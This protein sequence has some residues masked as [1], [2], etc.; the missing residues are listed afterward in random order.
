MWIVVPVVL[1]AVAATVVLSQRRE[2]PPAAAPPVRVVVPGRPGESAVVTDSDHLEAPDGS[3]YNAIDVTYAQMMIAHHAQAVEMA[4]LATGRAGNAGVRALAG[5]ISA[6]QQPEIEVLRS[7]LRDRGKPENEP[8]H[9]HAGMPGMQTA[10]AMSTLAGARGADF[11]RR[12]VTMM[13]EHHRGAQQMAGDLLRGGMDQR[14]S[15]MAN[16]TA[17]EQGS[18]INRLNDLDVA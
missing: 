3:L 16:E 2:E 18:E 10:A 17:V 4:G 9:D 14:L 15:E 11:D 13:I 6:A 1:V 5:R 8:G 7:W 12:F